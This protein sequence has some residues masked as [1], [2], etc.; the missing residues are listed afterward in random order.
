MKLRKGEITMKRRNGVKVGAIVC[1]MIA[2]LFLGQANVVQGASTRNITL[3]PGKVYQ[4]DVDADGKNDKIK[5]TLTD[6]KDNKD[7]AT[8]RV[9]VDNKRVF[10][11]KR[12]NSPYWKVKLLRLANGEVFF[13]ISSTVMSDDHCI[14]RLYS[15][16]GDKLK[17]VYDFQ[18]FYNQYADY[19]FVEVERVSG[20]CLKTSVRAQFYTTGSIR[21]PMNLEYE[22]REFK[23]T[24][25]SLSI[26]YKEMSRINKWTAQKTVEVYQG[27]G[28]EKCVYTL[29]KGNVI[30]INKVVYKNNKLYFQVK[31]SQ[32][33]TGYIPASKS[34][35][36]MNTFKEAQFAG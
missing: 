10:S 18:K 32:G 6:N 21:F 33:K 27:A 16:K 15:C 35:K 8:M 22:D 19:Y 9:L 5:V 17:R 1:T 31:N 36:S 7:S 14:H 30:Q 11:Q 24:S 4:F 23:R 25:D 28:S 2:G 12:S 20:N 34:V 29:K 13:D 3:E 26:N